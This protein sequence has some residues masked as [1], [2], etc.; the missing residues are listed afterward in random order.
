[1]LWVAITILMA[2]W[3]LAMATSY[4]MRGFVHVLPLMA[5]T[6]AFLR[7]HR[8]RRLRRRMA[9]AGLPSSRRPHRLE[10]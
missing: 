7:I 3:L 10:W 4:T 5:M 1:M 8:D 2:A 9:E 6:A